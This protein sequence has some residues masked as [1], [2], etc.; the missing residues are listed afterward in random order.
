MM[1][2]I[3]ANNGASA[4]LILTALGNHN[5]YD[6]IRDRY[7]YDQV[8]NCELEHQEKYILSVDLTSKILIVRD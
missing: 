8:L 1:D 6:T 2:K 5:E 4:C 3:Y 7:G